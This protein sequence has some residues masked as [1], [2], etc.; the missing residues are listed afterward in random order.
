MRSVVHDAMLMVVHEASH[1]SFIPAELLYRLG[2]RRHM[3]HPRQLIFPV[4][5]YACCGASPTRDGLCNSE[6][7]A[8]NCT[9]TDEEDAGTFVLPPISTSTSSSDDT[10]VRQKSIPKMWIRNA[11]MHGSATIPPPSKQMPVIGFG[12]GIFSRDESFLTQAFTSAFA[13]GY[14]L[15]DTASN[16]KNEQAI[17]N[18]LGQFIEES[19]GEVSREDFFITSKIEFRWTSGDG[20]NSCY[21]RTLV[22]VDE[23]L[24]LFNTSYLDL[25]LLHGPKS[26]IHPYPRSEYHAIARRN[27]WKALTK[28]FIETDKLKAIGVSN[29]SPRHIQQLLDDSDSQSTI[30]PAV[31]QIEFHPLLQRNE[32]VTWCIDR[33]I[34]VQAYGSGGGRQSEGRKREGPPNPTSFGI[35]QDVARK[36]GVSSH[37]V[38]LRWTLQRGIAVVP[39]STNRDHQADN[40]DLMRFHLDVDD[41]ARINAMGDE[42]FDLD[43]G[44]TTTP[45]GTKRKKLP[46]AKWGPHPRSFYGFIDPEK[47]L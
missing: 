38:I 28:I 17:G 23:R 37:Q 16:Y 22:T 32:T 35:I 7:N 10:R 39:M 12:G 33:G 18:A 2:G 8:T 26:E 4:L 27:A 40:L 15:I 1:D 36:H 25:V 24:R 41:M 42:G 5:C 31:N 3:M 6:V 30:R 45:K 9:T 34:A 20:D 13:S 46:I 47:I 21:N 44:A 19:G 14:R 29:W 43:D 11:Y